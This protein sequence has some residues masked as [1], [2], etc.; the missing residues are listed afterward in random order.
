MADQHKNGITWTWIVIAFVV[1][2]L[3][4]MFCF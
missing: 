4:G 3:I 2:F 1:G